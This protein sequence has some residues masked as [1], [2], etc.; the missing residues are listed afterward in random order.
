MIE[1]TRVKIRQRE[2]M[3]FSLENLSSRR[4]DELSHLKYRRRHCSSNYINRCS[5]YWNTSLPLFACLFSFRDFKG[6]HDDDW[7]HSTFIYK[8]WCDVKQFPWRRHLKLLLKQCYSPVVSICFASPV[9]ERADCQFD[10]RPLKKMASKCRQNYHEETEAL[11]NKQ[12]NIEQSLYYQYLALVS[13]NL[14]TFELN[15]LYV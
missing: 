4:I 5:K 12:I 13:K 2:S 9:S 6:P 14:T 8:K 1:S 7:G 11:V 10:F 15:L 3:T